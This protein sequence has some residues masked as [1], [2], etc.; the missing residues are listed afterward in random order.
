MKSD[1]IKNLQNAS[2]DDTDFS[3]DLKPLITL[4]DVSNAKKP[5]G[6]FVAAILF[7]EK[8]KESTFKEGLRRY[9]EEH[10]SKKTFSNERRAIFTANITI[11]TV[12]FAFTQVLRWK[13]TIL[14]RVTNEKGVETLYDPRETMDKVF[15]LVLN[16]SDKSSDKP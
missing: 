15:Q 3:T 13:V 2:V 5:L 6:K 9:N 10:G 14:F 4:D 16:S 1:L 7:L 12:L 8:V 11:R